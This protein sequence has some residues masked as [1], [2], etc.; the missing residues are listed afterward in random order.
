MRKI[1]IVVPSFSIGGTIV[2]LQSL[3]SLINTS[4]YNID[5][6]ALDRKGVYL[7][8]M[9]NCRILPENKW[10]SFRYNGESLFVK[11]F[12]LILRT[13]RIGLSKVG[14]NIL[15]L[16]CKIG[17]RQIGSEQ[18]DV[19]ISFVESISSVVCYYPAKKRIAWIH[20]EYKRY[21]ELSN[22]KSE[23]KIF[24]LYDKIVCVSE[25]AKNGFLECIPSAKEKVVAIHNI[26]NEDNIKG[27]ADENIYFDDKFISDSFTI[28]SVGRL[29]PVKQ[30][31]KIPLIAKEIKQ[32]TDIAFRWYIIGGGDANIEQM[33]N[34]NIKKY[35]L[36][37][38]VI[39][40]GAKTNVYPYMKKSDLYVSTSLSES[41]PLVINEAK[42]LNIPIVANDF[43]SAKESVENNID[44]YIVPI[45]GM[46][47]IIISLMNDEKRKNVIKQNLINKIY[48][49]DAL[50]HLI[51]SIL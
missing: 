26:I 19:V 4:K 5:I 35:N 42:V 6:F 22:I 28:I 45:K 1:L 29:D 50:Y 13:L 51:Y 43:G 21:L 10:L 2:S 15:P 47:D 33:I 3:L 25:F 18:Y 37:D 9:P 8:K 11:I 44:G 41:F 20:C 24:S 46:S 39:L 34:E 23:E 16:I 30:F 7:D 48:N 14:I 27:K 17:G 40:L 49:N 32:K 31:D 36:E 12:V 38:V